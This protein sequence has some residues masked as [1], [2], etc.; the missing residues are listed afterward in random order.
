MLEKN[1]FPSKE[2]ITSPIRGNGQHVFSTVCLNPGSQQ[3]IGKTRPFLG[4]ICLEPPN[5]NELVQL[6]RLRLIL[7]R[8][9]SLLSFIKTHVSVGSPKRL[10]VR[11]QFDLVLNQYPRHLA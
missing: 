11:F 10:S 4:P 3:P 8:F 2:S 1:M 6:D 5:R 9:F 7:Q